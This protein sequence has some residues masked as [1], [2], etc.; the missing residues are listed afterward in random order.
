MQ[1]FPER[2]RNFSNATGLLCPELKAYP[3]ETVVTEKLQA[4]G[5]ANAV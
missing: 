2:I 3:P 5:L 4:I 1:S